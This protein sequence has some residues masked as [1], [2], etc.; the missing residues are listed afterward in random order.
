[1]TY[2]AN[3]KLVKCPIYYS[4]LILPPLSLASFVAFPSGDERI[5]PII[6][7]CSLCMCNS[8]GNR[9]WLIGIQCTCSA[10][11]MQQRKR[12]ILYD[13]FRALCHPSMA[14][15]SVAL[16]SL[17]QSCVWL[18]ASPSHQPYQFCPPT[19]LQGVLRFS[20]SASWFTAMH[21]P[22]E[23]KTSGFLPLQNL[24]I[25]F[26]VKTFA[27]WQQAW[28]VCRHAVTVFPGQYLHADYISSLLMKSFTLH[29]L[30]PSAPICLACYW[31]HVMQ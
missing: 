25:Q 23:K 16:F 26:D 8:R 12:L 30:D 21:P 9:V 17:M 1:M 5:A 27:I 15:S 2:T 31:W 13:K 20:S 28:R 4:L 10:S 24:I 22:Q 6:G 11:S 7:S 14:C 29:W 18:L 3:H 19:H